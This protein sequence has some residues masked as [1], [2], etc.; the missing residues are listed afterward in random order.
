MTL[1]DSKNDREYR[2]YREDTLD[3]NLT[4]QAVIALID[5]S[6]LP[7]PVVETTATDTVV[8]SPYTEALAV[9]SGSETDMSTYTVPAGKVAFLQRAEYGGENIA[10]YRVKLNGSVIGKRRTWFTG[11][12]V[13]QM[14]WQESAARGLSLIAGDVVKV[15]VEHSRIMAADF[16]SRL[17][18]LQEDA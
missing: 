16:E 13:G 8:L 15:T 1:P 6:Q 3:A 18:I 10:T 14:I 4:R 9:V 17:V 11:D 2:S 12:L 5:P 7:L